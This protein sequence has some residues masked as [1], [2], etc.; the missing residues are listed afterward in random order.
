MKFGI[1]YHFRNPAG[2]KRRGP[3]LYARLLD[4]VQEIESLGYDSVWITEHHFVED[5]YTPSVLPVAAAIASRTTRIRIGTWVLLLPLHNPLRVAEDALTV[6]QFADGRFELGV[7]LGYRVEEFRAFGIP[8]EERGA[9]MTEGLQVLTYALSGEQFSFD[10]RFY[11]YQDVKVTPGPSRGPLKLYCAARSPAAA[12]RAA[13]F[14]CHLMPA[15]GPDVYRAY[16]TELRTRGLDPNDFDVAGHIQWFVSPDPERA[17][18]QLEPHALYQQN[19]Y[20]SW[21]DEAADLPEDKME[22]GGMESQLHSG[23]V[24][25]AEVV[26]DR[27]VEELSIQPYTEV[28]SFAVPPGGDLELALE[29]ARLFAAEVMPGL[30]SIELNHRASGDVAPPAEHELIRR[31]S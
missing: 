10:G 21:F 31:H 17:W 11:Q 23:I 14:A 19:L 13:R 1:A 16:A 26:A 12:T 8:R 2:W 15:G 7:G 3:D 24:G 22:S 30:R 28:I 27:L 6:D 4:H 18:A 20:N 25:T 9:R 5:G 29:S